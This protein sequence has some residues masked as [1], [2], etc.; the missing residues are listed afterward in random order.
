MV[1]VV[2]F[3]THGFSNGLG[4]TNSSEFIE[5]DDSSRRQFLVHDTMSAFL[6]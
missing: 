3:V 1:Y 2:G 6:D 5:P 4:Q